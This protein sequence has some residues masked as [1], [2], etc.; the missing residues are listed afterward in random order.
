VATDGTSRPIPYFGFLLSK[1]MNNDK[2]SI[3]RQPKAGQTVNQL[4]IIP[5]IGEESTSVI[6]INF[7]K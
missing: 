5:G 1:T 4:P 2:L 6:D 7:G 3:T